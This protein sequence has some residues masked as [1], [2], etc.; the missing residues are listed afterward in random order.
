MRCKQAFKLL[1]AIASVLPMLGWAQS[2]PPRPDP[3]R[4][5]NDF[6]ATLSP[7]EIDQLEQKLV[8]Y[9]DSTS[10]Q[11]AIVIVKSLEGF[12][13]EDYTFELGTRWGIG[14]EKKDNGVL[15]MVALEDRK[16]FIATGYGMEGTITDARAKNIIE[17]AIKPNFRQARYFEGL[18]EATDRIIAYAQGEYVNEEGREQTIPWKQVLG[19]FILFIFLMLF[20]AM[21]VKHYAFT[22]NLT[23]WTAW[24]LLNQSR[25]THRGSWG[26]FSSGGGSSGGGF[27]GFG[28]G[29]FG[30]GGAG[31]SW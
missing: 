17:N 20:K 30:G 21:Q 7:Q 24:A 4:L 12:P 19:I 26:G 29:S 9:D 8:A 28:G 18:Q 6:S 22:N 23:F 2:Y 16:T 27:G 3:P 25:T 15:I 13:I 14:R 11:I 10:T 1:L 31:G 5:V